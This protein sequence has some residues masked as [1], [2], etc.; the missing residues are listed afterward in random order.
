MRFKTR[1]KQAN[2]SFWCEHQGMFQC[3]ECGQVWSPCLQP[4]GRLP[5]RF[6]LCPNGCNENLI[7]T[8]AR[9]YEHAVATGP[10][11]TPAGL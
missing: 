8:P 4:G 11:T 2:V 6:W 10:S 1:M 7:G 5:R 9:R 3:D